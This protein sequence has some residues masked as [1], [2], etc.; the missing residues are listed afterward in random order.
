MTRAERET[1]AQKSNQFKVYTRFYRPTEKQ[2]GCDLYF[3]KGFDKEE[4][5]VK[6]VS[7]NP[8]KYVL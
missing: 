4:D 7:K 3:C 6:F 1:N 8:Q 2:Y 5:A